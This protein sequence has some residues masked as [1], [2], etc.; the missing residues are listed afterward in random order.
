MN[1]APHQLPAHFWHDEPLL[2]FHPERAEDCER[3]PLKGLRKFGPL[4]GS[5][6]NSMIDPIRVAAIVPF[7]CKKWFTGIVGELNSSHRPLER[8]AYLIDYP[9]FTPLFRVRVVEAEG[10]CR[11]VPQQIDESLSLAQI[12]YRELA[13][14]LLAELN[15]LRRSTSD[16]DVLYLFLPERWSRGFKGARGDDFDLHDFLKAECAA[17]AI[18]LQILREDRVLRYKCRSSVMWRL[19]MATYCKAGGIPWRIAVADP[20]TAFIG[21]S[22]AVRNSDSGPRFVNC[23]SQVFDADGCGLQFL[24]YESEEFREF[25]KNPFLTREGMRR[26]MHRSR[27]LYQ[28]RHDGRSPKRIVVYKTTPFRSEEVEGCLDAW[29]SIDMDLIQ[30][31]Q[32]TPWRGIRVS[33]INAIA[34]YPV[35]RGSCL[36]LSG[37]E[38]L[39]WTQ[40]IVPSVTGESFYAPQKGIPGPLLLTRFSGHSGWM[41]LTGELLGLTKMNWNNDSLYDRLP[42]TIDYASSLAR[43]VKR[44]PS[45][46]P[47]PY[48]FRFFM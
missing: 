46:S 12:P 24:V 21:L 33:A 11:E 40:G 39:F 8:Q 38:A 36:T 9:G 34:G 15:A 48:D 25:G 18:P 20:G 37:N 44:L 22:Y 27:L 28:K 17:A 2:S 45:L 3:H 16:F 30:I 7:G 6:I 31:Q 14:R 35:H 1:I 43:I 26:L 23:C 32:D 19:G 13:D 4:S 5:L 42:V 41:E 10:H 29:Q 47:R